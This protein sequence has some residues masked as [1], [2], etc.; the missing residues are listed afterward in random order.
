MNSIQTNVEGLIPNIQSL[1]LEQIQLSAK[2]TLL[3]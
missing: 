2:I 3:E 1:S